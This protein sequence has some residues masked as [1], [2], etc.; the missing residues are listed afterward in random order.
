MDEEK[1]RGERNGV[2]KSKLCIYYIQSL[3]EIHFVQNFCAKKKK[4][5]KKEELFFILTLIFKQ[6]QQNN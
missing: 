4:E 3:D 6:E 1:K 5:K 2:A